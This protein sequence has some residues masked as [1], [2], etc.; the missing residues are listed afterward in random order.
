MAR[1]A[2]TPADPVSVKCRFCKSDALAVFHLP[3]GCFCYPDDRE[4]ALCPQHIIRATPLGEMTLKEVLDADG[5]E[6]FVQSQ[7]RPLGR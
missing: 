5:W 1:A 2:E 3:R 6:W 7:N 4:Q